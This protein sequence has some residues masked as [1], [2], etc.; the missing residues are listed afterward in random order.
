MESIGAE[1]AKT[2]LPELLDR[3]AQGQR[4]T[5][6]RRGVPVAILIPPDGGGRRPASEVVDE[7]LEFRK[8]LRLRGPFSIREAIDEGRP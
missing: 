7:L 6:T 2:H 8:Q 5:F 4:I 3:V 1:K